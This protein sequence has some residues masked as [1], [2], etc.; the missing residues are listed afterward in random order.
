MYCTN[1]GQPV[2]EDFAFCVSCGARIQHTSADSRP[3]DPHPEATGGLLPNRD[4]MKQA[5]ESLRGKWGLAI[6]TFVVFFL[7][8]NAASFVPYVGGIGS[9]IIAGPLMVGISIFTLALYRGNNADLAQIF[10]GFR[11]FG[12]SFLAYLLYTL[13]ILL[14]AI[15]FSIPMAIIAA[16]ILTTVVFN[17]DSDTVLIITI[18]LLTIPSIIIAA[19]VSLSYSQTFWIVADNSSIDAMDAVR[20]SMQIMK[21]NKW[22]LVCLWLRFIGW[23]LLCILTLGIGFLWLIPYFYVS[24]ARFYDDI[25]VEREPVSFWSIF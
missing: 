9:F 16:I 8:S 17:M 25:N 12:V 4:I 2:R 14:W 5:R 1:C 21:G 24:M 11:R 10:W 20:R 15:I 18:I 6:G 23:F 7:I 19:F 22:K 3:P 13:F